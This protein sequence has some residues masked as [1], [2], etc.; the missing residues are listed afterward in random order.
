MSL[1]WLYINQGI[2]LQEEQKLADDS[3]DSL[4]ESDDD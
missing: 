2:K 4:M 1:I 3:D